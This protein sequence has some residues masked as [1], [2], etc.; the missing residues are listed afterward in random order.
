MGRFSVHPYEIITS[1]YF[2]QWEYNWVVRWNL[3]QRPVP[4]RID[5]EE[6][7]YL[8]TVVVFCVLI[9][10]VFGQDQKDIPKPPELGQ[11]FCQGGGKLIPLQEETRV[12]A[13]Y[14]FANDVSIK[15][16][17]AQSKVI[18][19]SAATLPFLVHLPDKSISSYSLYSLTQGKSDRTMRLGETKRK[20]SLA[21][22]EYA[23]GYFQLTPK[24]PLVA[25]QYVFFY[26]PTP[27][28]L[29]HFYSFSVK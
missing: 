23:D 26:G 11:F 9:S 22:I 28:S 24:T 1:K 14:T 16:K 15:I 27:Q 2:K 29:D 3:G 7:N 19:D 17:E 4:K 5:G 21:V 25:G 13:S 8:K 6:M 10:C 20:V 12:S 18:L